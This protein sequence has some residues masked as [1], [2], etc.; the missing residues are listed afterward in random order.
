MPATGQVLQPGSF[1]GQVTVYDPTLAGAVITPQIS[2]A[3]GMDQSII[4]TS[5]LVVV[6]GGL[7]SVAG[8]ALA[9]LIVGAADTV[10][11]L[12]AP[13]WA[14]TF[15]YF[16]VILVLVIRPWGIFGVRER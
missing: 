13:N 11:T 1:A 5:L 15:M 7:G 6:I 16:A 8:T 14:S 10:G 4:V 2:V 9:S 12:V 3:P